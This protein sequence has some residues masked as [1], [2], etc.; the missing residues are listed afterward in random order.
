MRS[1]AVPTPPNGITVRASDTRGRSEALT[2]FGYLGRA[3][4]G[5][6]RT[7]STTLRGQRV[8]IILESRR[9]AAA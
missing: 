7:P 6:A 3:P 9:P 1:R 2:H 8:G 5:Y 4:D